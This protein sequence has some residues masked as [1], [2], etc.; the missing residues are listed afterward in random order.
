MS[1]GPYSLGIA[2]RAALL[3]AGAFAILQ[4]LATQRLYAT[5]LVVAAVAAVLVFELRRHITR[6]DRMLAQFV[7]GLA[8]GDF[9]RPS[10]DS[11]A[12]RGFR[13]LADAIDRAAAALG[14]SRTSQQRQI[15]SLQALLD[16]SG[17]AMLIVEP[18]G[19]VTLANRAA[20]QLVGMPVATLDQ[21]PVLGAAAIE[22]RELAPGQ[23]TVVRLA[24]GQRMLASA[25]QFV[26]G[27][28]DQRVLSLQNIGSELDE[29]ELQAWH[30]LVRILAHEMMNS[31][32]PIA[33]LAESVRPLVAG[34]R[35]DAG[36]SGDRH[37]ADVAGAID[38]IARRSAGLMSF[39]ERYR[40][41]AERPQPVLRAVRVAGLVQKVE[42]LMSAV[43]AGKGITF[44]ASVEQP[45]L[46]IRADAAMLEQALLNLLHNCV[47]ALAQTS[48]SRIEVRCR[49]ESDGVTI[50]VLDNGPGIPA[51]ALER[52]FVPFFTTKAGGSG[53]GLSLA[54]QIAHAHGGRLDA[55]A[56]VPNGAA[57]MLFLPAA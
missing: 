11:S 32:T 15:E 36:P 41:M 47:D 48:D 56:N 4:L 23:R 20:R 50:A 31:L 1:A 55:A 40:R 18:N 34:L 45:E 21:V 38:T 37:V 12:T 35:S 22:L 26:A 39:V 43:L 14:A 53:I 33:S 29:A 28:V 24:N 51:D 3:G 19:S 5:A 17:V 49:M 7:S 42:Q 16:T 27:T 52:I 30:D 10:R 54:R 57:F 9:E 46:E 44:T 25:A 8:A 2:V 6:G 13:A